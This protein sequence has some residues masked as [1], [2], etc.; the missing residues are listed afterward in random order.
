MTSIIRMQLAV[1]CCKAV[2][3]NPQKIYGVSFSE[4]VKV[5]CRSHY[6]CEE[7][8]LKFRSLTEA[9]QYL[10]NVMLP[11]SIEAAQ[12]FLSPLDPQFPLFLLLQ[13]ACDHSTP[14]GKVILEYQAQY[15]RISDSSASLD[16]PFEHGTVLPVDSSLYTVFEA[17]DSWQIY[18]KRLLALIT[19]GGLAFLVCRDHTTAAQMKIDEGEEGIYPLPLS[20]QDPDVTVREVAGHKMLVPVWYR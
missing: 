13:P 18:A 12:E 16:E 14:L 15:G 7:N 4:R 6:D 19:L 1:E 17:D 20:H 11:A 3:T 8:D 5:L 9:L 2:T 10:A